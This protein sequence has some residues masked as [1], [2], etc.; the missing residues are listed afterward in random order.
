MSTRSFLGHSAPETGWDQ[1]SRSSSCLLAASHPCARH[2]GSR[3]LPHSVLGGEVC[4][5]W[6]ASSWLSFVVVVVIF[7]PHIVWICVRDSRLEKCA[8][9]F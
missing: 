2:L 8:W 6:S 7:N 1:P 5:C 9:L 4:V 3:L